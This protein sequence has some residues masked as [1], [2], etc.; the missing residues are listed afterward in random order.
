MPKSI[1]AALPCCVDHDVL[2]LQ[3]A[4]DDAFRVRGFERER[5]L[6]H[7]ADNFFVRQLAG[8]DDEI[9][10]ILPL[11]ELHG[12]ELDAVGFAEIENANYVFVGD[13]AGED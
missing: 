10:E 4:V 12:D 2:R 7:D 11:D 3:I 6:L 9:F 1:T 13:L 8:V 5:D